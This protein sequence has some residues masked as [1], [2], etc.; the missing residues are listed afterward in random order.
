MG[1]LTFDF[2]DETVIVTGASSGIGR[3][4]ALAFGRAG[5]TV[6]NADVDEEPKDVNANTPTHERITETAGDGHY[7]ETDVSE[8]SEIE[9]VVEAARE[10]GGL[11][12][13]VNNAGMIMSSPMRELDPEQFDRIFEV[14]VKGVFFG[15]QAAANDMLDRESPGTIVNT[16]STSSHLAQFNQV[17]YDATKGA[18]RMVTR[19]SALELAKHGI[20]VNAVAPGQTATEM[21]EGW[22]EEATEGAEQDE[23]IKPV[24]M[25]RAGH[26]DEVAPAAL[27]LA[28]DAASYV[29]G[30]LLTVDGG[31]QII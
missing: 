9:S 25:G 11:D 22:T 1:S 3:A 10:F 13:M 2:S 14:N 18:V 5:A 15:C 6:I 29:T 31:W 12:V 16:A 7:V 19:G 17:H 20:R 21:V 30:E 8:P 28:S 26:P 23:F 27:F 4:I 24:P